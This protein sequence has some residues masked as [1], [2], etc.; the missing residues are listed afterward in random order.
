MELVGELYG[1]IS[2][3]CGFFAVSFY[4]GIVFSEQQS[5]QHS[6]DQVVA[7]CTTRTDQ[8]NKPESSHNP[9]NNAREVVVYSNLSTTT[10]QK[11]SNPKKHN[12]D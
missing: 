2:G 9:K 5:A 8:E 6:A 4:K 3:C 7:T 12:T 11:T 10:K 1:S